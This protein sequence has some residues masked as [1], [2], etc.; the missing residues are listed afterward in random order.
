MRDPLDWVFFLF[1]RLSKD[2][3]PD[4]NVN[5]ILSA[6]FC[7]DR[8]GLIHLLAFPS[9]LSGKC[10]SIVG[11]TKGARIAYNSKY[12]AILTIVYNIL[13]IKQLPDGLK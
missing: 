1:A 13:W 12:K 8:L 4:N 11:L 2:T 5:F 3:Q 10:P 9:Q 7:I 6:L